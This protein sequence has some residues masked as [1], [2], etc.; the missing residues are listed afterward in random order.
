MG[1]WSKQNFLDFVKRGAND[2][3]LTRSINSTQSLDFYLS[4]YYPMYAATLASSA[5]KSEY[6]H[7]VSREMGESPLELIAYVVNNNRPYTE[8]L[9]ADYTLVGPKMAAIL[10]PMSIQ[11]P[12]NLYPPSTKD[13][14]YPPPKTNYPVAIGR[15]LTKHL[16]SR[17]AC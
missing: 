13:S 16:L 17:W 8:I 9:T 14:W 1:F 2:R 4:N 6:V 15:Q 10:R 5:N 12:A 11:P 3:L 7:A